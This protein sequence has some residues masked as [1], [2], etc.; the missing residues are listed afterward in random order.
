M[1]VDDT[2][3]LMYYESEVNSMEIY[4]Y[5]TSGGKNLIMD[6]I[7]SLSKPEK[8]ELLDIRAEIR[9]SGL[10]AFEKLDTRQLRGKL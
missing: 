1:R 8:L 6:Y 2:S 4:D 10:D 5:K 9:K 3:K 7:E